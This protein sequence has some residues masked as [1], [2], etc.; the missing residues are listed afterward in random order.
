MAYSATITEGQKT[1]ADGSVHQTY[2][3][4]EREIDPANTAHQWALPVPD[5]CTS[6]LFV[7]DL[8]AGAA[9]TIQNEI[10]VV[11]EWTS[12][13]VGHVDKIDAAGVNVRVPQRKFIDTRGGGVLYG[14][15]NP[16]INTGSAAGVHVR[17]FIT[18]ISGHV[19]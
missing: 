9:A 7:S 1:V 5:R 2:Q 16:D 8:L 17:T 18:L 15:S 4:D 11:S 10:G 12:E 3:I 14:R 19:S 13:G 6:T